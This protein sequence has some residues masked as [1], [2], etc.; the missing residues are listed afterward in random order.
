[1]HF[2]VDFSLFAPLSTPICLGRMMK[3]TWGSKEQKSGNGQKNGRKLFASEV[4]RDFAPL[5]G[6][7]LQNS[8]GDATSF[9]P[10]FGTRNHVE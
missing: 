6:F 8:C 10:L 5:L 1:M 2:S 9:E 4:G 3:E 7:P